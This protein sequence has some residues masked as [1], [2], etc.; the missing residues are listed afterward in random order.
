MRDAE[1]IHRDLLLKL[2]QHINQFKSG[3]GRLGVGLLS[4]LKFWLAAH[5]TGADRQH[6][7]HAQSRSVAPDVADE[8][9]HSILAHAGERP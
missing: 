2:E 6:A 8:T 7:R 1:V 5:I 3:N 4:F 9:R